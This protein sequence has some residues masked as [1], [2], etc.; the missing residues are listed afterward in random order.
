M[1]SLTANFPAVKRVQILV[2]DRPADARRPRRPD[3]AAAAGH[4]A[5]G[6]RRPASRARPRR[7]RPAL[8][9]VRASA[10]AAR[11]TESVIREMTRLANLHGAVNLSQGFPDFPAPEEV[12]E[13]ARAAIAADINQYA[14]TW[15]A[16]SLR[17]AIAREVRAALRRAR[18]PRAR[19]HRHLRLDR[20]HD[21]DAAGRPRSRRRG[22]GLRAVLRELR[23]R[24]HPLR[25]RAA[26][27]EAAAAG[28]DASTP[29]SWRRAFSAADARDHRQHA[30]QPDR[31]GV[32]A[33][34]AG[35]RSPS[36]AASTT[37]SPSP[38]RST[39]TSSTTAPAR[40]DGHAARAWPSARSPSTA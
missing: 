15:G 2:E 33:R 9:S 29:T 16:R 11:F 6:R 5:A 28:L 1:N 20:G 27:R 18:R 12:K 25:R 23:A 4:D 19:G 30:E 21:R 3:A 31:Q 37:R 36:S 32:H 13:A 40:P 38:T 7:P 39:S 17:E 24:R 22:R 10:K 8:V 35:A 14:I 26:L 34:R